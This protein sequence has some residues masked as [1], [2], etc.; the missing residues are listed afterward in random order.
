MFG[1][2]A[3]GTFGSRLDGVGEF[4]IGARFGAVQMIERGIERFFIVRGQML[5]KDAA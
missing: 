3:G 4:V 5:V 2:S 1:E